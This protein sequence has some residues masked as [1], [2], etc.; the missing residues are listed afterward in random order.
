MKNWFFILFL[1]IGGNLYS[2]DELPKYLHTSN[3]KDSLYVTSKNTF[4]FPIHIVVADSLDRILTKKVLFPNDSILLL[5]LTN[6]KNEALSLLKTYEFTR[7]FGNPFIK[8]YDTLYPYAPP[9]KRG[10]RYKVIQGYNGSYTHNSPDS[11]YAIDFQMPVGD[12]ICAARKGVVVKVEDQF[13]KGGRN[14]YFKPYANFILIYHE[15]GTVA[16]YVHLK[17]KGVFVK[18]GDIVEKE[19]VIGL[20]GN[21]GW[22]TEPHL[23]FSVYLPKNGTLVSIPAMFNKVSGRKLKKGIRINY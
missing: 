19:Q 17:H 18:P 23:H 9:F 20:S 4:K 5:S 12:T 8:R 13:H 11:R 3:T 22:S 16:Q 2:Q 15:D 14:K 1:W 6:K 21:T 7:N 10:H